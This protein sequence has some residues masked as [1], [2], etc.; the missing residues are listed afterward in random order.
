M[1]PL[2]FEETDLG[3]PPAPGWYAGIIA[4]ACW[5]TSSRGHRMVYVVITL[6]SVGSPYRRISDYFVLEGVTPR[7]IACSRRRLV[8]LFYAIL[9]AVPLGVH[10]LMVFGAFRN[11]FDLSGVFNALGML[12]DGAAYDSAA[13]RF[14][15]EP[16]HGPSITAM[17]ELALEGSCGVARPL[18]ATWLLAHCGISVRYEAA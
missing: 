16:G 5:R 18:A 13:E 15:V 6:E 14:A 1:Q 8:S 9:V 2:H 3:G 11:L 17:M 4:T 12:G 7:G 10:R